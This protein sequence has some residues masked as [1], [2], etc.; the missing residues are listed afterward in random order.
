MYF[1]FL[2]QF[3]NIVKL[4]RIF[5]IILLSNTQVER[6]FSQHKFTKTHLKNRINIKSLN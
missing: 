6:I 2:N 4:V 3:S 1:D 5:L